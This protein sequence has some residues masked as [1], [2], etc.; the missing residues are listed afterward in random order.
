M[1]WQQES[2]N[3]AVSRE[4]CAR[5]RSRIGMHVYHFQTTF[6]AAHLTNAGAGKTSCA[7]S[8]GWATRCATSTK[9]KAHPSTCCS[10]EIPDGIMSRRNGACTHEGTRQA[11]LP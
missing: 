10:D 5:S 8:H 7:V 4:P 1:R 11:P 3:L 9:R 2:D 6:F